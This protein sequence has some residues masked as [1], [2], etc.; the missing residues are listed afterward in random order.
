M[1]L[2][3]MLKKKRWAF[4]RVLNVSVADLTVSGKLFHSLGPMTE[5]APSPLVLKQCAWNGKQ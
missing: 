3:R 2:N 1:L 4:R 5:K